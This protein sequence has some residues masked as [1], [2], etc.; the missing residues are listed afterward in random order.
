M[1]DR[2]PVQARNDVLVYSTA[3]LSTPLELTG[4]ITAQIFFA[5]SAPD[6]DVT[7]ALSDVAPDG[8]ANLIQDGI[9]RARYR[10]GPESLAPLEPGRVYALTI[11]LWSTSYLVK[12]GHKLR[13]EISSSCFNRYDRNLNTGEPFGRD[14]TPAKAKQTVFH[15][16][17]RPSHIML[18][19]HGP[20]TG[21]QAV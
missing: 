4:P 8:S 17:V 7:V 14:T 12:S 1:G 11:D 19:I 6:T 10:D 21:G 16:A 15:D 5:S 20:E 3:S 9:L 2:R 13:V 18:P